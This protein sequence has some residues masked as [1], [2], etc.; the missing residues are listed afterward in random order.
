[1]SR[2]S[3]NRG[4]R[5]T[6]SRGRG[7]DEGAGRRREGSSDLGRDGYEVG[8]RRPPQHSRFKPGKSGN[9]QGRPKRAKNLRTIVQEEANATIEVREGGRIRKTTKLAAL[10]KTMIAKALQGD[11]K[12]AQI[13]IAVVREY[14]PQ[15]D[16]L[17]VERT[18]L[19]DDEREILRNHADFLALLDGGDNEQPDT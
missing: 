9:P 1:M 19:T 2:K 3:D 15:D 16:P 5:G 17:A 11:T 12:A 18:P 4:A 8:Y 13:V 6:G 10:L 7:K 14:L